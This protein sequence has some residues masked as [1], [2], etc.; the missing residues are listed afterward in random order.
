MSKGAPAA[1]EKKEAPEVTA[2]EKLGLAGGGEGGESR[3]LPRRCERDGG[4]GG[5]PSQRDGQRRSFRSP[6]ASPAGGSSTFRVGLGSTEVSK[7]GYRPSAADA[8][9]FMQEL[10]A[11]LQHI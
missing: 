5:T 4:Q 7:P 11:A 10:S 1:P 3:C 6:T 2:K 9:A 8:Q